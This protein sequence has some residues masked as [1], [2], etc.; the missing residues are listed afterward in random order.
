MRSGPIEP[1]RPPDSWSRV[2]ESSSEVGLLIKLG[3][4]T[5]KNE[6]WELA[7]R[8]INKLLCEQLSQS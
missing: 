7:G 2:N 6:I 8:H 1:A 3:N 4:I 5:M